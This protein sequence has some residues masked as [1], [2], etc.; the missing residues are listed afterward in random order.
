MKKGTIL[1]V[2]AAL[3][4]ALPASLTSLAALSIALPAFSKAPSVFAGTLSTFFSIMRINPMP[5][6]AQLSPTK[7]G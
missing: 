1:L 6:L 2:G 3:S 4:T 7:T 5:D